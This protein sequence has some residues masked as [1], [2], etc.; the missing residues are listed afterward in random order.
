MGK[1]FSVLVI[2]VATIYSAMPLSL[3]GTQF[4]SLY[5]KHMEKM[6]VKQVQCSQLTGFVLFLS[7]IFVV[8]TRADRRF[9]GERR[10]RSPS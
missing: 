5:E 3:V 10:V 8:V 1:L 6:I 4:Y 7:L 9:R 2:I